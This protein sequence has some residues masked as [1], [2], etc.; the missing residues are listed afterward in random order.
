MNPPYSPSSPGTTV[1]D[2]V[3]SEEALLGDSEKDL[4][5]PV[6]RKRSSTNWTTVH[7][8]LI[9]IYTL[10]FGLSVLRLHELYS[11]GTNLIFCEYLVLP[12]RFP[13]LTLVQ[14][15]LGRPSTP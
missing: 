9:F 11:H 6:I 1:Y 7:I 13:G 2:P 14:H 5:E 15:P 8:T 10:I 12:S 3:P 4:S